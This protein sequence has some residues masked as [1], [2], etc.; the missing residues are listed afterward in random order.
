MTSKVMGKKKKKKE[1]E[2]RNAYGMWKKVMVLLRN[3]YG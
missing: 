1:K 2:K 3:I